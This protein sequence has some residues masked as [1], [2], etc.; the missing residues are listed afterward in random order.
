MRLDRWAV[1]DLVTAAT[2]LMG[3]S[4]A[5]RQH[6]LQ[7]VVR[8]AC[9]SSSSHSLSCEVLGGLPVYCMLV[10]C[11]LTAW[12]AALCSGLV[13]STV[14]A[15]SVGGSAPC[16]LNL[17]V[18]Y[19]CTMHVWYPCFGWRWCYAVVIT[20]SWRLGNEQAL[21]HAWRLCCMLQELALSNQ[22]KW[23]ALLL[24]MCAQSLHVLSA[25]SP[26]AFVADPVLTYLQPRIVS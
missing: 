12:H 25:A 21:L 22:P 26:Y 4:I 16:D 7:W 18:P 11:P 14:S 3:H 19:C 17:F 13:V 10:P 20:D 23:Y 8:V 24:F 1:S 9:I 2:F 6:R 5:G 15:A